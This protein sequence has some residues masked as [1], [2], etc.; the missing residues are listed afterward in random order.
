MQFYIGCFGEVSLKG[1]TWNPTKWAKQENMW[2]GE[3][4]SEW[5]ICKY[6]FLWEK[7]A[8]SVCTWNRA[9]TSEAVYDLANQESREKWHRR[10]ASSKETTIKRLLNEKR[11]RNSGDI[12]E[13]V[14]DEYTGEQSDFQHHLQA[15]PTWFLNESNVKYQRRISRMTSQFSDIKHGGLQLLCTEMDEETGFVGRLKSIIKF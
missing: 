5:R 3:K 15:Q 13:H 7:Q 8:P 9:E 11:L 10:V 14:K 6:Q 4:H 12:G 2:V 1:V